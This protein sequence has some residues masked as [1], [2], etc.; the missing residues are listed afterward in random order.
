VV[1]LLPA[2]DDLADIFES[3]GAAPS[4][5]EGLEIFIVPLGIPHVRDRS[6]A[7]PTRALLTRKRY[8]S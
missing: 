2:A 5:S 1:V 7:N 4:A 6:A 8:T 3:R